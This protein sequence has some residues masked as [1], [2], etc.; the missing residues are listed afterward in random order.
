MA[1]RRR[2]DRLLTTKAGR[3]YRRSY[4]LSEVKAGAVVV[5]LLLGIAGWVAWMGAHPDPALFA[6][7]P[8]QVGA[9][10]DVDRGP[11]PDDLAPAGWEERGL[12]SFGPDNVYEKINGREGFYKSFGF[13]ALSFVAFLDPDEPTRGVD[14][15]AYDLGD[16]ANAVGCLTAEAGSDRPPL[17]RDGALVRIE[18]N[19]RF[20]ARG[21]Y[22]LRL[23]ASDDSE[24]STAALD[25]LEARLVDALP[26]G[27]LPWAFALLVGELG[28]DA[29]QVSYIP[30]DAFSIAAGQRVHAAELDEDGTTLF[31]TVAGDDPDALAAAFLDGFA[32]LGEAE[33]GSD[34]RT[35]VRDRY[36][37]RVS[38][39]LAAA[40]PFVA[41]IYSA[42]DIDA[43]APQLDRL[44]AALALLP[45]ELRARALQDRPNGVDEATPSTNSGD[46]EEPHSEPD[47]YD[48]GEE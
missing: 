28:L 10:A 3:H 21:R 44:L 23:I 41:G 2:E 15:E 36:Q 42:G 22:Y 32:V 35:W 9:A 30:E 17:L 31:V 8:G 37:K 14:V 12:A 18:A 43:V 20:L 11:L 19:A 1:K 6:A 48:E 25:H 24:R 38:T 45:P 26:A 47:E 34:G 27:E 39:A 7:A 16:S 33:E 29:A 46:A 4:S 13:V 40:P 5:L